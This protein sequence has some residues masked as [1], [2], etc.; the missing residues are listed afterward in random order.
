MNYRPP[1]TCK[2]TRLKSKPVIIRQ[3]TCK[4][5][6]F[7][8]VPL[9]VDCRRG[10]PHLNGSLH[11]FLL[12]SGNNR[13]VDL[14]PLSLQEDPSHNSLPPRIQFQVSKHRL[15]GWRS[16]STA[17]PSQ[18]VAMLLP[19]SLHCLPCWD[20]SFYKY[21]APSPNSNPTS[22]SCLLY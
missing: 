19:P 20:L 15:F 14:F 3:S 22:R 12:I 1:L 6:I 11:L 13:N 5:P 16:D 18:E 8:R 4:E 21:T 10:R 2:G 17:A 7:S 9:H